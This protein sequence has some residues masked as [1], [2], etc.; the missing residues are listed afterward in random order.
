[1]IGT[2]LNTVIALLLLAGCTNGAPKSYDSV[3]GTASLPI[4]E[5]SPEAIGLLDFLNDASTTQ[6]VLDNEIGLDARAASN[7]I[8]HRDGLDRLHGSDDDNP[9]DNLAEVD[10]VPWVG[11]TTME[12]LLDYADDQGFVPEDHDYLGTWDGVDFT[13]FQAESTLF[14]ANTADLD[15]LDNELGLDARAVDS[16]AAARLLKTIDE[17]ANLY[18]VGHDTLLLLKEGALKAA[19]GSTKDV[20]V[21]DLV[22]VLIDHY[23]LHQVDIVESGGATLQEALDSLDVAFVREI[24]DEE[25]DPMSHDLDAYVVYTHPDVVFPD[26]GSRWFGIYDNES[27]ALLE[28]YNGR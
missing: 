14:F 26:S 25:E 27:G 20:F 17:L 1:M 6:D 28:I 23:A 4:A 21:L 10:A 16:I 2:Q 9:F 8:S 7:L 12:R 22:H 11:P 13:V 3:V 24:R 19:P 18:Y 15:F 5:G